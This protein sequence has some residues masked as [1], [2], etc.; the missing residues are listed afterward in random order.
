M[1]G[2]ISGCVD[3]CPVQ[4]RNLGE[5]ESL[6]SFRVFRLLQDVGR[7]ESVT[8]GQAGQ[9]GQIS[10]C[11]VNNLPWLFSFQ[12]E[13]TSTLFDDDLTNLQSYNILASKPSRSS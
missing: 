9:V 8:F 13:P 4:T 2:S 6:G 7:R 12:F 5:S 3:D 10:T 11:F 1:H